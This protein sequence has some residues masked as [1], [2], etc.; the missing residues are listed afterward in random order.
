MFSQ[1][2]I[3][4]V[5]PDES[6]ILEVVSSN[7]GVILPKVSLTGTLDISTIANPKPGLLVYNTANVVGLN[8]G[9][10][11][12]DGSQWST[13]LD[14]NTE[15]NDWTLQ[16]NSITGSEFLGTTNDQS[17]NFKINNTDAG[18][19]ETNGSIRLGRG[20][21]SATNNI[22]IGSNASAT[23]LAS[24]AIGFGANATGQST[25]AIGALANATAESAGALGLTSKA[26]GF[27]S[28][29]L[30]NAAYALQSYATGI[31]YSARAETL[32]STALGSNS[33]TGVSGANG[34]YA[35][36]IGANAA[37]EGNNSISI[38]GGDDTASEFAI[39]A[40]EN[41][42]AIGKKA[43]VSN[44]GTNGLAIGSDAQS[45]GVQSLA[46]GLSSRA[47]ADYSASFGTFASSS[48]TF[49]AAFGYGATATGIGATAFGSGADATNNNATSLGN[50]AIASGSGSSVVGF[51]SEAAGLYASTLGSNTRANGLHA[52]AIGG[53]DPNNI[54]GANASGSDAIS[55]G[56][57]STASAT[58]AI[59]IGHNVDAGQANSVILGNNADVGIGTETPDEK[60]HVVGSVKIV[61][62]TQAEGKVLTSDANGVASWQVSNNVKAYG[63]IYNT[64]DE[65]PIADN[66][67]RILGGMSTN[68][69]NNFNM[70]A[71]TNY[72]E[73]QITGSYKI[74][75]SSSM[76]TSDAS[77]R[78]F[79]LTVARAPS[80]SG[81]SILSRA[82]SFAG[83]SNSNTYFGNSKTF[84]QS[85]NAGDRIYFTYRTS[86]NETR[87]VG[88]TV[89]LTAEKM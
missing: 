61:D 55:I 23:Q 46:L 17:L 36:A 71:G 76:F 74:T 86:G 22:V 45:T 62:G 85:L 15:S 69:N 53:G 30:G 52:I 49:T 18:G 83:T 42:I 64:A 51:K 37:A 43:L 1:V 59:A 39:A 31:G 14:L 33:K 80:G 25:F 5:D 66:K 70:T 58:N 81:A 75:Y 48:N 60:L 8:V 78:N 19:I 10:T 6:S 34:E 77:D 9:Y 40:G 56:H 16:G 84:I 57:L 3:G 11:Y 13:F 41:S 82:T 27:Q 38:G 24:I 29:A 89:S 63:E 88:N 4:T 50:D 35:T 67:Y 54:N 12:W 21:S 32:G 26:E 2:G 87:F 72:L 44:T 20:T 65:N 7:K 79:E 73:I 47:S 28:T 68:A